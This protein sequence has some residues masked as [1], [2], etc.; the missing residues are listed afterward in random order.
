[1]KKVL[2]GF[3][4]LLISIFSIEL[5]YQNSTDACQ[6]GGPVVLSYTCKISDYIIRAQAEEYAKEPQNPNRY[7]TGVADSK[8]EFKILEILKGDSISGSIILNGYL[9]EKDDFNDHAVPYNFVRSNGRRGSCYANT[10]KKGAEYLLFMK[11]I[12]EGFTVNI[13]PLAPV[14]EQLH[15]SNDPWVY[16]IKGLLK[17]LEESNITKKK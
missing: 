12:S 8:V 14:N 10:Y 17:G 16:Y 15:S 4:V 3:V 13:D 2:F 11:K 6:R 5:I 7:T 1:M 9:N